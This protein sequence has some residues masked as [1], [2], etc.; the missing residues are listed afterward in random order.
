[1]PDVHAIG[2][3]DRSNA[4]VFDIALALTFAMVAFTLPRSS[5][6]FPMVAS[7]LARSSFRSRAVEPSAHELH[8]QCFDVKDFEM[9]KKK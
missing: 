7:T 1:L 8:M 2:R 6:P 9:K 4:R 3:D 5:L